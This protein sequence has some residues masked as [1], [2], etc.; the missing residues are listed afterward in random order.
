VPGVLSGFLLTAVRLNRFEAV[1]RPTSLAS[2]I[3][4]QWGAS[5]LLGGEAVIAEAAGQSAHSWH[6]IGLRLMAEACLAIGMALC[7]S[8]RKKLA[9]RSRGQLVAVSLAFLLASLFTASAAYLHFGSLCCERHEVLRRAWIALSSCGLCIAILSP[10]F[11]SRWRGKGGV[12]VVG[13]LLVCL[14]VLL[15]WH[16][17]TLIRQYRLYGVMSYATSQNFSSGFSHARKDM[18]FLLP[19]DTALIL[20]EQVAPGLYT[21]ESHSQGLPH[22]LLEYFH[23]ERVVVRAPSD[24]MRDVEH[25]SHTG[26]R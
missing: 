12:S 10:F 16:V 15:M 14:S 2:T 4:G 17:G 18:V 7:F 21:L 24:W 9:T 13:T 5:L 23:K 6:G 8:G 20:G 22:L 25:S 11:A 19:P 1:E 26:S 3:A